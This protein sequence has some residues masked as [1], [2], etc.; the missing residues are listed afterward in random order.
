MVQRCLDPPDPATLV[1]GAAGSAVAGLDA[2]QPHRSRLPSRDLGSP[3]A[4][5]K[6]TTILSSQ[7]LRGSASRP[8]VQLHLSADR[9]D[10]SSPRPRHSGRSCL[11]CRTRI[12]A[13]VYFRRCG[14]TRFR[15]N[16]TPPTHALRPP[17][18]R[19]MRYPRTGSREEEVGFAANARGSYG[20]RC[21]SG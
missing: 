7:R 15:A 3:G 18:Q 19:S 5:T 10:G 1:L 20:G 6:C 4:L 8:S 12:S 9:Q 21:D 2:P 11:P 14:V 16:S 17:H 13:S